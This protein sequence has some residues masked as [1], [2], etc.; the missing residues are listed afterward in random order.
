M[1]CCVVLC[2]VVLC[3]VVLCYCVVGREIKDGIGMTWFKKIP[4]PSAGD[5][6]FYKAYTDLKGLLWCFRN[7]TG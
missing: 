3:C 2:C 7:S 1:L 5:E 6:E 4:Q